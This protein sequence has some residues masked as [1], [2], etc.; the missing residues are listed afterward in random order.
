MRKPT[1]ADQPSERSVADLAL[2]LTRRRRCG[3]GRNDCRLG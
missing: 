2:Q 3:A 1:L